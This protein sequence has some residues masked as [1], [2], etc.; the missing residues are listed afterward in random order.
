[1]LENRSTGGYSVLIGRRKQHTKRRYGAIP[2]RIGIPRKICVAY[3]A[4][5]PTA[6][7]DGTQKAAASRAEERH[8]PNRIS[9][10]LRRPGVRPE[11]I[12][13]RT[14]TGPLPPCTL[15]RKKAPFALRRSYRVKF[16][17]TVSCQFSRRTVPQA[18]PFRLPRGWSRPRM[19]QEAA[20][21]IYP[22][23]VCVSDQCAR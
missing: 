8:S 16:R 22:A 7:A 15:T 21:P 5:A 3:R 20:P 13:A 23:N 12:A 18:H 9:D 2:I 17:A 11:T 6:L 14:E 10:H 1:M 4:D 19:R